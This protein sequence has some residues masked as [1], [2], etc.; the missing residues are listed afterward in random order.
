MPARDLQSSFA[1]G[2]LSPSLLGRVDLNKYSVGLR[3]AKNILVRP[4][5]A[6]DNRPGTSF[7]GEVKDSARKARLVPFQFSTVQTYQLEF[8]HQTLRV[9]KDGA[10]V[11]SGSAKT[12]TAATNADP[13]VFTS[14]AH[15]LTNGTWVYLSGLTAWPD[16][17]AR[18]FV[19]RNAATNTFTLEDL[20]GD[21][22]DTTSLG[23]F[24][25]TPTVEAYYEIATPYGETELWDLRHEQSADTMWLF[26]PSYPTRKLTRSGHASWS[27]STET[28]GSNI[29][30]PASAGASWTGS[31]G[32]D[33][34]V[35]YVVTAVDDVTGEESLASGYAN[36]TAK[37]PSTWPAGGQVTI[38]FS[39][40]SGASRYRIYKDR[41][42]SLLYGFIGETTQASFV[43]DNITA[44][45]SR[46]PPVSNSPFSGSG[47]YPACG[48][49][50]EQRMFR[51]G[52]DNDPATV[53]ASRT[54]RF[55]NYNFS[56]PALDT[57]SVEFTLVAKQVNRVR[58]LIPLQKL[59]A[60]T[61]H[62][63]FAID[64]GGD[65]SAITP[66]N[67]RAR[68]QSYRGAANVPPLLVGETALFVQAGGNVVR[69]LGYEFASNTYKGI[70]LSI[71]AEHLFRNRSVV[72]WAY[73]QS[74]D[75]VIWASM[76]D[77]AL[78]SMT[79]LKEHDVIAWTWHDLGG[80]VEDVSVIRE[81]EMD[82]PYF[83]VKR[84]VN[85]QTK[86]YVERLH[87][88]NFATISDAFFVDAGLSYSG[89][90]VTTLRG[91]SHLEGEAVS[92]LADGDVVSGKTVSN[93]QITL[94]RE[95][96]IV[97]VGL[98]YEAVMRTMPL[99]LLNRSRGPG[100]GRLK[101]ISKPA[102]TVDRT[103]GIQ[104]GSR[105]DE[106]FEVPEAD[107]PYDEPLP[108]LTETHA[109]SVGPNWNRE[110]DIWIKQDYPL[111]MTV[112]SISVEAS[113]E[114][115]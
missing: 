102:V 10:Y 76:D 97:H 37:T 13:G 78:L 81:G 79:Y 52:T 38:T 17:N 8:G 19:V 15:G 70:D 54:G 57:D 1:G 95:A 87:E 24:A 69:E 51:A 32:T 23:A 111:P 47:D 39:T 98:G 9:I 49:F 66:S 36:V 56:R 109:L 83:V 6:A 43:D 108:A 65:D 5:G 80:E 25:G 40:V 60:L 72:S 4:H 74:P 86:R 26:H 68:A 115:D 77:G 62:T 99:A 101:S 45:L 114:G 91:L 7:V 22:L 90:P 34:T 110:G 107:Y 28:T 44:D 92:I 59:I 27:L 85:S 67:I 35:R 93:G 58:D 100:Y 94:D 20:W 96:S 46:T 42:S 84:T 12:V 33:E 48:T 71:M 18:T 3:E 55:A 88:R 16:I 104:I 106:L 50:F 11:L 61:T 112:L 73:A 2:V 53:F 105:E 31:G 21:A 64:G 29:A 63:I 113:D 30:T 75:S 41:K 82:V 103:R 14:N 89:S